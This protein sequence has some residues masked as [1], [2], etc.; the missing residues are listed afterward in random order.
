MNYDYYIYD[1]YIKQQM[2][3]QTIDTLINVFNN[4]KVDWFHV[5]FYFL[6]SPFF[7]S[8]LYCMI[9]KKSQFVLCLLLSLPPSLYSLI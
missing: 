6:L 5:F 2:I 9:W 8:S 1:Y 7:S 3:L 4:H